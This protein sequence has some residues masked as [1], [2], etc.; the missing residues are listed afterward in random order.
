MCGSCHTIDLP[1][2]DQK[3]AGHNLEQLTYLEWLNSSYQNEFGQGANAQTCQDCHM[4]SSYSNSAGTLKVD[5][6]QQPFASV[7][8]DRYPATEHRAPADKIQ[9]R[10]RDKGFVRHQFQGLNVPLLEMFSQFM[11]TAE[12]KSEKG[13]PY[14]EVLGVRQNDYMLGVNA[15][16]P[17]AIDAF[18]QQAQSTTAAIK[19]DRG[20]IEN[21]KLI[22]NVTVTNNTGHRFP[23]GVGFR[24][25]FIEF[26]A[27]DSRNGEVVWASG[28][29]NELGIIVDQNQE[30]LPS[31]F[32]DRYQ[33]ESGKSRQH[34]QPHY[35]D[36][37]G[38]TITRQDQVQIFEELMQDS[39]GNFTT[40]F[41]RRDTPVKDN[42][43]LPLGW[44]AKG[45]DPSLS[46]YFLEATYPHAVG[47]DGHYQDGS[48]TSVVTYEVPLNGIDPASLTLTATIYHQ[49]IP[50]Y[51][52]KMRFDEA[53][54]Y[55]ATKRL[56]YLAS[57]LNTSGTPIAN[58]KLKIVSS[59][60]PP[61][62]VR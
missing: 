4:R 37:A 26:Q 9:V 38:Q 57:N 52:L 47:D 31:E 28:R 46:G 33:D 12:P 48:G 24:R 17:N 35:Y 7:E 51:Y 39:N 11:T 10:F 58:W 44:T 30:P 34:Y 6:I 2:V 45:P 8:D 59:S 13:L 50:P 62:A 5:A 19:I 20:G 27:I 60:S 49:S 53:P 29:T 41:I 36:Q 55:P 3:P 16:L 42:R 14:N 61:T 25:A 22:A 56:Y 15:D 1:V 23:S 18:V 40:S 21:G 43:L 54:D 32:F